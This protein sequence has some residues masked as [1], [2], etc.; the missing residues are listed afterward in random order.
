MLTDGKV[1]SLTAKQL[2]TGKIL[3]LIDNE[4]LTSGKLLHMKTTSSNAENP[5]QIELNNMTE[6]IGVRMDYRALTSGTGLLIDSK[7]GSSLEDDGKLVSIHAPK[8][9]NGTMLHINASDLESGSAITIETSD[10]LSTGTLLNMT[11]TTTTGDPEGLVRLTAN[12][13][14]AAQP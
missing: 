2:T 6:G 7:D 13:M 4:A 11:T 1:I 3:E 9:A 8:Q 5:V 14:K 10:K 12:A